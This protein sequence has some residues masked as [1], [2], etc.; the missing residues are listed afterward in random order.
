MP[1]TYEVHK[2]Q[3]IFYLLAYKAREILILLFL[4]TR[5]SKRSETKYSSE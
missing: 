5:N 1:M 3:A 4:I 2:R